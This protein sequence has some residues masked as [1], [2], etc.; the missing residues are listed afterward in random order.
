[1]ILGHGDVE[2]TLKVYTHPIVEAQ[3]V[4]MERIAGVLDTV[5]HKTTSP[6]ESR[7]ASVN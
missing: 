6:G 3:R 2:T 1:M 4:A 7:V 5:G